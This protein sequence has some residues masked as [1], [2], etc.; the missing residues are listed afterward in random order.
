MIV[1]IDH[2]QLA[3]PPG[4]EARARDF[5]IAVLGMTEIDKPA[6][7]ASRG[8]CWFAS[9]DAALHLGVES[10]FRPAQKAH[11]G[12]LV[13]DL[14]ALQAALETAGFVCT[15]SDG[16]VPGV[17]RFHTHDCFGNRLEFQEAVGSQTPREHEPRT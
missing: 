14:A 16:D 2:V 7:L 1:G 15:R 6:A 5:Y 8:G 13:D 11:P 12:L 9:G 3:M 17:A 4:A 10:D